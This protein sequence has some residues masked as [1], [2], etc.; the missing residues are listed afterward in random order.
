MKDNFLM[1]NPRKGWINSKNKKTWKIPK[2]CCRGDEI[3]FF[4]FFRSRTDKNGLA[5]FKFFFFDG[6]DDDDD[7]DEELVSVF[8]LMEYYRVSIEF[9][10]CSTSIWMKKENC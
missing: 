10:V 5:F 1:V 6:D 8:V 7:D 3:E 4:F 2:M 9:V